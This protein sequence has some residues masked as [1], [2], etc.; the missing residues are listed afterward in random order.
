MAHINFNGK[1]TSIY[2]LSPDEFYGFINDTYLS[3]TKEAIEYYRKY[4]DIDSDL[5]YH[6]QASS[7]LNEIEDNINGASRI[8]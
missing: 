8:W 7:R 2:S 3:E 6:D 1:Y 5:K 4:I